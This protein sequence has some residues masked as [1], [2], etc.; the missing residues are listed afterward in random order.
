M[1]IAWYIVASMLNLII[2]ALLTVMLI[3][4]VMSWISPRSDH[5]VMRFINGVTDTLVYPVRRVLSRFEFVRSFPLDISF[6]VT[7]ILLVLLRSLIN[8][9]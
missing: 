9:I 2:D 6:Y 3:S 4:A 1:Y 5:P 8:S 7:S